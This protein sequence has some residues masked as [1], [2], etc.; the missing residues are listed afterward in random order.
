M[1]QLIAEVDT[2]GDGRI[3][4]EE[5]VKAMG[6]TS[7][8]RV[9]ILFYFCVFPADDFILFHALCLVKTRITLP[10]TAGALDRKLTLKSVSTTISPHPHSSSR[11]GSL[12]KDS[13]MDKIAEN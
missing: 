7:A 6:G 8:G 9:F 5:W 4:F 11:P 2:N 3:S 12:P 13:K 1:V 10:Y